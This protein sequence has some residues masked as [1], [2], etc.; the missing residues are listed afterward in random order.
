MTRSFEVFERNLAALLQRAYEPVR[1][2]PAFRARVE[3]RF[4]AGA[5]E[6]ARE[7]ELDRNAQRGSQHG[8]QHG[9]QRGARRAEL[10]LVRGPRALPPL[11]R[12]SLVGVAA[13]LAVFIVRPWLWSGG[14]EAR[15]L[16]A[17]LARGE[18]ASRSSS[19]A[20]WSATG[21]LDDA[22]F[23]FEGAYLELATPAALPAQVQ[24][25]ARAADGSRDERWSVFPG[26][27]A[28]FER[29]GGELTLELRSGGVVARA[30]AA[31]LAPRRV[32]S[33]QGEFELRGAFDVRASFEAPLDLRSFAPCDAPPETWLHVQIR[34]GSAL[35][36]DRGASER[37]EL[38][39]GAE[40]YLC[41]GALVET[42]AQPG[43][44]KPTRTQVESGSES[45][46]T[47]VGESLARPWVRGRV[48]QSAASGAIALDEFVIVA[49]PTVVLPQ[50]ADP[51]AFQF[52]AAGGAFELFGA[53]PG[54][55]GLREGPA[56]L[57]AKAPGFAVARAEV[58]L[59]AKGAPLE[60]DFELDAG[61]RV[62]GL[63]VDAQSGRPIEGAYVVSE[64]DSQLAVLSISPADNRGFEHGARTLPGGDFTLERLSRGAHSLRASAPGYGQ[65]WVE[66]RELG[67][68]QTRAGVRFELNPAGAIAG[69]VLDERLR[70]VAGALV[71]AATTDFERKRPS[72][73]YSRVFSDGEGRYRVDDLGAGAWALLNFGAKPGA[74]APEY[75]FVQV[76]AGRTSA[77]D[78]KPAD[79]GG[80]LVGRLV[81]EQGAPLPGRTVMAGARDDFGGPQNG[82]WSSSNT[83]EQGRFRAEG[84][85]S[86]VH[87][88]Y[89]SGA[90]PA[91]LMWAGR[92]DIGDEP[93][94]EHELRLGGA[95]LS[96][97]VFDGEGREA[98]GF[99]VV[100][101]VQRA[102]G[103]ERFQGRVFTTADGAYRIDHL[104]PGLYD[105]FAYAM[106]GGFGQEQTLGLSCDGVNALTGV[107]FTLFA[108]GRLAL[109][110][111]D[112]SGA[113]LVA[114]LE[115][116][117]ERGVRVQ[118]SD[119][120]RSNA[121]GRY[122]VRGMKPG[123]WTV[124]ASAAGFAETSGAVQVR[125]GE[126]S[127]LELVLR[128]P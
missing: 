31:A 12:W 91:E 90:T 105:V 125:A 52:R 112:E 74:V 76:E 22:Q 40:G 57:F 65:S 64:H 92:V 28:V 29:D 30:G 1:A 36:A 109:R 78:F 127:D 37:R 108:G 38:S 24:W 10:R 19:T 87:E 122:N 15:S 16:E 45:S 113:A 34:R 59:D 110:I 116:F 96:G 100:V 60:V 81:D 47:A 103:E 39:A 56:T 86:G 98:M 17:I 51:L 75:R 69:V 118:F 58:V 119:E 97:R 46:P 44:S 66:V 2:E 33:A 73:T 83:D 104:E 23:E 68:G 32:R 54:K 70:P 95:S 13:M 8:N 101:V 26:S 82:R 7:R 99:A 120:D 93:V 71:I 61:A 85:H 55:S 117:D 3:E 14:D 106:R 79:A 4:V 27:R 102:N 72:V 121:S 18:V 62:E 111:T 20:S 128:R 80:V 25:G 21:G 67:T 94:T 114:R 63:V 89:V 115:F 42:L 107:D 6:L 5:E 50:V 11:A 77:L 88:L 35:A 53:E 9:P 49:L 84:L 41:G 123:A 48:R 124:K 43:A 126:R